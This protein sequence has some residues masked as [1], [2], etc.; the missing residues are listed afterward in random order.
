MK[1]RAA[2]ESYMDCAGRALLVPIIGR[3]RR[4]RTTRECGLI[5]PVQ[6]RCLTSPFHTCRQTFL[7]NT[8]IQRCQPLNPHL[9]PVATLDRS[10]AGRCAGKNHI[11]GQQREVI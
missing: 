9:E 6:K 3:R 10:N 5:Y 11:A 8:I 4:F 2:G 7:L 1:P